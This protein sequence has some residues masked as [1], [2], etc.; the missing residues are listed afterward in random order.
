M[1]LET[2]STPLQRDQEN[3]NIYTRMGFDIHNSV[4]AA[5]MFGDHIQEATTWLLRQSSLGEF[6]KRFK[7]NHSNFKYTFYKSK[8]RIDDDIFIITDY[9]EQYNIIQI[10][11]TSVYYPITWMTLSDPNIEW[12]EVKHDTNPILKRV[13]Y[14]WTRIIGALTINIKKCRYWDWAEFLVL[15]GENDFGSLKI[16]PMGAPE[17]FNRTTGAGSPTDNEKLIYSLY[18][19]TNSKD[20][21]FRFTPHHPK[22]LTSGWDQRRITIERGLHW[23]KFVLICEVMKIPD[24]VLD[25]LILFRNTIEMREKILE[26]NNINIPENIIKDLIKI[27]RKFK[28]PRETILKKHKKWESFCKPFLNFDNMEIV[29]HDEGIVKL[30]IVVN[31]LMFIN[32]YRNDV[33]GVFN[34]FHTTRKVNFIHTRRLFEALYGKV[35]TNLKIRS[36]VLLEDWENKFW[37]RCK[38]KSRKYTNNIL[39][40]KDIELSVYDHQNAGISWLLDKENN[41]RSY[42]VV[43]WNKMEEPDGFTWWRSSWGF[44]KLTAASP[45][46]VVGGYPCKGGLLCQC[47][48][49]GKSFELIKLMDI[50]KQTN[51]TSKPTLI[52]AP[53]SMLTVWQDE[54][55]KFSNSLT[56]VLYYGSRRKNID[57][58]SHD[59]IITSYR[60]IVNEKN[61]VISPLFETDKWGRIIC[62]E[63]HYMRDIHSKTFKA[64]N[65]LTAP[66]KWCI[67]AT[68]FVKSFL[69]LSSYLSFF[70]IHPFNERPK[71]TLNSL[72]HTAESNPSLA[73][74]FFNT[75]EKNVFI[76]SRKRIDTIS[77]LKAPVIH[78][79]DVTIQTPYN[80]LYKVLF[81]GAKIR[82]KNSRNHSQV[83]QMIQRMRIASFHPQMIPIKY[84][85]NPLPI[86]KG[87]VPT[88]EVSF[89]SFEIEDGGAYNDTIKTQLD[90]YRKNGGN[91]CICMDTIDRPTMTACGHMYCY[92]CIHNA[93]SHQTSKQCPICRHNLE[94]KILYELKDDG[95]DMSEGIND[96]VIEKSVKELYVNSEKDLQWLDDATCPEIKIPKLNWI[97]EKIKNGKKLVIFTQFNIVLE[98]LK[99]FLGAHGILY[100]FINGSMPIKKRGQAIRDFQTKEEIKLFILTTKSANT[101]I[102]LTSASSIVFMEP[103]VNKNKHLQAIGRINR[104]GQIEK[105]LSVYTLKTACSIEPVINK[106]MG[107]ISWLED[108]KLI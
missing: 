90:D 33:L 71:I 43:G 65:C 63:C 50:Q 31:D 56:S 14:G 87:G 24:V 73:E 64:I 55:N 39:K 59:C 48:G 51:T 96:A 11:P 40:N 89:E 13:T 52:I 81:E 61:S 69:D 108:N 74:I 67:S 37:D 70:G 49:A 36:W 47:V 20:P 79:K 1:S 94:N 107:T 38:K 54:I 57:L 76:Q 22:I 75:I 19:L 77:K 91:C 58:N 45:D 82:I 6:P 28:K 60:L 30:D 21:Q 104:L 92:E 25:E 98:H 26:L 44:I 7:N 83:M 32:Q 93:F 102:T 72:L 4:R 100:G 53:T 29:D 95:R 101:G 23:S 97:F 9:D 46:N 34:S 10:S 62:D 103:C 42:G 18:R 86:G 2:V 80:N 66:I 12:I 17:Y 5:L 88:T 8:I 99:Y 35:K 68:P 16:P 41:S 78:Y 15:T 85:G 27:W 3:R 106:R 105:S 84:Y